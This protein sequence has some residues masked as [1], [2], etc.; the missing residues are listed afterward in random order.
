MKSKAPDQDLDYIL[1][2][3]DTKALAR[4]WQLVEAVKE[5]L[6]EMCALAKMADNHESRQIALHTIVRTD[7]AIRR[8]LRELKAHAS[9]S[10][11]RRAMTQG[12]AELV[13]AEQAA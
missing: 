10:R 2:A 5:P 12:A 11:S 8:Q 9:A 3:S 1:N 4:Y 6:D 13:D 7:S